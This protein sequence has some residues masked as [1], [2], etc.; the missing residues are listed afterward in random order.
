[1]SNNE[2]RRNDLLKNLPSEVLLKARST[3]LALG[4]LK[5]KDRQKKQDVKKKSERLKSS[6]S[7]PEFSDMRKVKHRSRIDE[8]P[9]EYGARPRPLSVG[10]TKRYEDDINYHSGS[11]PKDPT[12]LHRRFDSSDEMYCVQSRLVLPPIDRLQDFQT[13]EASERPRKKLSFREPE[14][15]GTGSATLGRS[16]KLM[17]V[18]SLTRRNRASRRND[19]SSVDGID[20][21]LESQAMR[22]VRT[23]GQA[24]EVC[25][26]MQTPEQAA[27]SAAEEQASVQA[28]EAGTSRAPASDYAQSA[29]STSR[30]VDDPGEIIRPTTLDLPQ[31]K[32]DSKRTQPGVP[33]INLLDLPECIT[34]VDISPMPEDEAT[35]LSAQHQLQLLKERLEQQA[36]QTRAA[37]AQLMLLRDQLAAEQAARCEAQARTHQLLVHNKE[38]LEHIA[39]LVSHLQDREKGSSRPINAQQLTL[40]PQL[41]STAKIDRWFSLLPSST[42]SRPESGFISGV[43]DTDT[44]LAE[45]RSL[46][47]HLGVKKKRRLL[48]RFRRKILVNKHTL[49]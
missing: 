6:R 20:S 41:S 29:P 1:M 9:R 38:L 10:A 8:P 49:L 5:S 22:I 2:K 45:A 28:S 37:V 48:P 21:D 11:V 16:T 26:K 3:L 27:S 47:L 30:E 44:A 43:E 31:P 25:H 23:V 4:T 39:A 19:H 34:K 32:K 12:P 33:S 35:P 42:L 40:I 15:V 7:E 24:F 13:H 14:I 17:G 18:N 36:Q 46:L